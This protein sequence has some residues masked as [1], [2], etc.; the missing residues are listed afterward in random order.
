MKNLA[1]VIWLVGESFASTLTVYLICKAR[2]LYG[3]KITDTQLAVGVLVNFL[4]YIGI[5]ILLY[6]K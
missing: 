3:R 1:F 6:E 2:A 4:F 5:A